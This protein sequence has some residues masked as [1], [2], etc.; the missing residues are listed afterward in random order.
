[1]QGKYH[2]SIELHLG[3]LKISRMIRSLAILKLLRKMLTRIL[4]L[5]SRSNTSAGNSDYDDDDASSL[6][7][8]LPEDVKEG[9]FV[10]HTVDHGEP[11]RFIIELGYLAHPGFLKLLEQ[12]KGEFGFRPEGVLVVPCGTNEL[13]RIL[14]DRKEKMG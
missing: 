12:A 7:E 3:L 4:R 9:H 10:V 11:K 14:E 2:L 13:K 5:S 8:D 1:M 6:A